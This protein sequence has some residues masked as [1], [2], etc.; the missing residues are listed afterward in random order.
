M[1]DKYNKALD[2]LYQENYEDFYKNILQTIKNR[3]KRSEILFKKYLD[4]YDFS[5]SDYFIKKQIDTS[6]LYYLYISLTIYNFD[7]IFNN[8]G[9]IIYDYGYSFYDI[10]LNQP[11][12]KPMITLLKLYNMYNSPK[13]YY[14]MIKLYVKIIENKK[15]KKIIDESYK[16]I[17]DIENH[18]LFVKLIHENNILRV[19]NRNMKV[20]NDENKLLKSLIAKNLKY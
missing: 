8:F 10:V 3:Y 5:Q 7:Y 4:K 11:N 9:D 20:I 18:M 19:D 13:M 14:Q 16:Y 1:E 15:D 12:I 2:S 6:N 17:C